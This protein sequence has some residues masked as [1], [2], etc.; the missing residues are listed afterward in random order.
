ML[1]NNGK[2]EKLSLHNVFHQNKLSLHADN[3]LYLCII[4][5]IY[6]LFKYIYIYIYELFY[7]ALLLTNA[8]MGLRRFLTN[9]GKNWC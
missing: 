8:V 2:H 3:I 9:L 6:D 7:E 1:P 5:E 4:N